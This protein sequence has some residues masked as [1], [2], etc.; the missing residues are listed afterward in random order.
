[1]VL[2]QLI[3]RAR[4]KRV[5]LGGEVSH[6][7]A[8]RVHRGGLEVPLLGRRPIVDA[9]RQVNVAARVV[10]RRDRQVAFQRAP[11][12]RSF[13]A[14]EILG[15][16][17]EEGVE[18]VAVPRPNQGLDTHPL[19]ASFHDEVECGVVPERSCQLGEEQVDRS[20]SG[21]SHAYCGA[22]FDHLSRLEV[23]GLDDQLLF[24]H[25][26]DDGPQAP[27]A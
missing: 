22:I 17:G 18:A 6:L 2:P 5:E 12:A 26:P 19:P 11:G 14:V 1:M 4:E 20:R 7:L 15:Q 21:V 24:P 3:D 23:V 13:P 8:G 9:P 16:R 10:F 25:C 27:R